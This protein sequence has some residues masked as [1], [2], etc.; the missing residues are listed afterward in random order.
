MNKHNYSEGLSASEGV[1]GPKKKG[2]PKLEHRGGRREGALKFPLRSATKQYLATREDR[3]KKSTL[4]NE[5]RILWHIVGMMEEM[6]KEGQLVTSNPWKMGR[7]EIRAVL[8]YLRD[9]D[10]PL[11]NETL[12]KYIR[13]L[14]G[15]LEYCGNRV[16][17]EMKQ[18]SSNLFPKRGRKPIA[19]LTESEVE[20]VKEAAVDFE[21]WK[22]SVMRFMTAIY[23]ATGLRPSELRLARLEDLNIRD[24]TI[25]VMHPKGE[26]SYGDK[27]VV[28]I[29][30]QAEEATRA[31]L[32]ERHEYVQ[33]MG[34]KESK[35]LIPNLSSGKD[36]VYS[37][38]H[39]RRLKKELE[40]ATGIKFK[41]KDFRS[42]FASLT[43]QKDSSLMPE[44]SQQLGHSSLVTT[45]RFYADM[46]LIDTGSKLRR[47]W[48]KKDV[49]EIEKEVMKSQDTPESTVPDK[50]KNV[51]I[52]PREY[53]P[54]YA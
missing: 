13:Y 22:G 38:N 34:L 26:S 17:N 54:G 28:S 40:E 16:I 11:E 8:D 46:D 42:T 53:I 41:L 45:Q 43:V 1:N 36:K 25:K 30:P 20:R 52:R 51:L 6:E 18:D 3:V 48:S 44:V 4:N 14:E 5:S 29:M 37:S 31:F 50:A 12:E 39:F 49:V 15:V 32:K 27:R 7:K 19:H 2:R 9:S 47:A 33:R 10:R 23:P 35:H 24:M 21:G